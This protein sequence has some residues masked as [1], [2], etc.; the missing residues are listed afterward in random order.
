MSF[1]SD[2]SELARH[3]N[4]ESAKAV[5][6]GNLSP[7]RA[8][9]FVTINPARQLGIGNRTGSIEVGK[10][11]DLVLWSGDPLSPLSLCEQTWIEGTKR[12]DRADDLAARPGRELLRQQL[13]VA[14]LQ[15]GKPVDGA[16]PLKDEKPATPPPTR[17]RERML[18]TREDAYLDLWRRG[19]DL[20]TLS[21]AGVCGCEEVAR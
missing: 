19:L 6:Y 8:L 11:A 5:K 2:S 17:L 14:A 4:T 18:S 13:I 1:N 7:A 9:E 20:R 12:F 10:D 21:R 3:L 16:A 15:V